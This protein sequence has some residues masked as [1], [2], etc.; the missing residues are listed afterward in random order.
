MMAT[1]ESVEYEITPV[2]STNLGFSSPKN[3]GLLAFKALRDSKLYQHF[4]PTKDIDILSNG[5]SYHV[6]FEKGF[7]RGT[8]HIDEFGGALDDSRHEVETVL[9]RFC[10]LRLETCPDDLIEHGKPYTSWERELV[11]LE[12]EI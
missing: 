3:A 12:I 5:G 11:P 6:R 8:L 1:I 7:D 2:N 10:G 9:R 4:R